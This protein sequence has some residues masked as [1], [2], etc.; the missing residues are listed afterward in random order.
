MR[1]KLARLCIAYKLHRRLFYSFIYVVFGVRLLQINLHAL[2]AR[3]V[4]QVGYRNG[5]LVIVAFFRNR[6]TAVSKSSVTRAV[7]ER[8]FYFRTVIPVT[9]PRNRTLIRY[10]VSAAYYRVFISRLVVAVA[11][12]YAFLICN[13]CVVMF[14]CAVVNRAA[15]SIFEIAVVYARGRGICVVSPGI[16]DFTRRIHVPPKHVAHRFGSGIA[17]VTRPQTGVNGILFEFLHIHRVGKQQHHD[18]LLHVARRSRVAQPLQNGLFFGGEIELILYVLAFAF[19]SAYDVDSRVAVSILHFGQRLVAGIALKQLPAD[20]LSV[21]LC[22]RLHG[23][24]TVGRAL[25][26]EIFPGGIN[27]LLI[28][29]YP[30]VFK[31]QLQ[32][33][34]YIQPVLFDHTHVFSQVDVRTARAV[35]NPVI[36]P[37][38]VIIVSQPVHAESADVLFVRL[39]QRQGVIFIPEQNHTFVVHSF[40]SVKRVVLHFYQLRNHSLVVFAVSFVFGRIVI[41]IYRLRVVLLVVVYKERASYPEIIVNPLLMRND[42]VLRNRKD[43]K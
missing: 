30:A 41:R 34:S 24:V 23:F 37:G 9:V 6:V 32:S 25:V 4:A 10:G 39:A 43:C 3:N 13:V 22:A 2:L 8:I 12:V 35:I 18:N 21:A 28:V 27:Q 20:F 14:G 42:R 40:G 29:F 11:H 19:V 17:A 36:Y 7:S 38:A 15:V 16:H 33:G 5:N 1:L 26:F 31:R